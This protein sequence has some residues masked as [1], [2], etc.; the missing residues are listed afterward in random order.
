MRESV[1]SIAHSDFTLRS[2]NGLPSSP[3]A[4]AT[5]RETTEDRRK[6]GRRYGGADRRG[7]YAAVRAPSPR[8]PVTHSYL[9]PIALVRHR[10]RRARPGRPLRRRS[11]GRD[12]ATVLVARVLVVCGAVP[13]GRDLQSSTLHQVLARVGGRP[14]S[15]PV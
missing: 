12:E 4:M 13:G 1:R 10:R 3:H 11:V 5:A 15:R 2:D 8:G 6:Q 14:R 9:G 7:A